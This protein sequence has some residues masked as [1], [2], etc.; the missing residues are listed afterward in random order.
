MPDAFLQ[1]LGLQGHRALSVL[2]SNLNRL[3]QLTPTLIDLYLVINEYESSQ[4]YHNA[5]L[6]Y[7]LEKYI[8]VWLLST[9]SDG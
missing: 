7:N 6:F 3:M 8:Y 4:R 2:W 5:C 9:L 1:L